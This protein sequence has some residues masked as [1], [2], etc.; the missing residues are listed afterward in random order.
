MLTGV[1]D[2]RRKAGGGAWVG[3]HHSQHSQITTPL[4]W[5]R[6]SRAAAAYAAAAANLSAAA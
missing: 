3:Q 5:H 4:V 6:L 2:E 1:N